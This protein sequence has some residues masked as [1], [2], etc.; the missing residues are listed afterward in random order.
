MQ[1]VKPFDTRNLT[2]KPSNPFA[3]LAD[4]V[5]TCDRDRAKGLRQTAAARRANRDR[6]SVNTPNRDR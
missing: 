2:A 4:H 6:R 1:H 3:A 5:A